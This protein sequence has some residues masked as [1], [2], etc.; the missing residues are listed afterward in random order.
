[1]KKVR[2]RNAEYMATLPPFRFMAGDVIEVEDDWADQLIRRGIAKAASARTETVQEKRAAM[3]DEQEAE[4]ES[5]SAGER[6]A[7]RSALM[8]QLSALDSQDARAA[9]MQAEYG[10]HYSDSVTREDAAPT[11]EESAATSRPR[12]AAD[13]DAA[14]QPRAASRR[15]SDEAQPTAA[16]KK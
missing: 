12:A 4:R 15:A 9:E 6:A 16:A 5:M 1:M 7:Q 10:G 2:L 14:R 3:R 8:A 13:D 11:P